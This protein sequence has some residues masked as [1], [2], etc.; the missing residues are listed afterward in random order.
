M[1]P[2]LF[3]VDWSRLCEALAALVILSMIVERGLSIVFESKYFLDRIS[4]AKLQICKISREGIALIVAIAGCYYWKFDV[5]S[6]LFTA[7]ESSWPGYIATGAVVA[8]GSKASIK[9]FRDI[10]GFKSGAYKEYEEK[11]KES[12]KIAS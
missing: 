4:N 5:V 9:L 6:I 10:L 8:G 12:A 3:G 7:P 11:K 2:T 1:D